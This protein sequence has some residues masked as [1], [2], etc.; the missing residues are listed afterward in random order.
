MHEE[1]KQTNE[2]GNH[3]TNLPPS[4][5]LAPPRS[6]IKKDAEML[7]AYGSGYWK[8]DEANNETSGVLRALAAAKPIA[9]QI[10]AMLAVGSE[11]K[12]E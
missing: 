10:L 12:D 8:I 7:I 1:L 5:P 2:I 9:D 4:H 11:E 6:E 3:Y